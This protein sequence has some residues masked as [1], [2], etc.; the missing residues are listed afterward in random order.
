MAY[1]NDAGIVIVDIVQKICLLSMGTPDLYGNADPYQRA[2]RSPKRPGPAENYP[3]DR[4]RSPTADQV[5][6]FFLFKSPFPTA[7]VKGPVFFK[8]PGFRFFFFFVF[9]PLFLL[10]FHMN[11]KIFRRKENI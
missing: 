9:F 3:D 1:G 7:R 11:F 10:N 2:P 8:G 6:Y 5:S 4:C